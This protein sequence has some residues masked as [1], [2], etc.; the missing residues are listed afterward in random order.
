MAIRQLYNDAERKR[1]MAD[2]LTQQAMTP[3]QMGGAITPQYGVGHGLTQLGQA[4]LAKRAGKKADEALTKANT[5]REQMMAQALQGLGPEASM[6]AGSGG[7]P[8]NPY[9]QMQNAIEAGVDPAVVTA[10]MQNRQP[11]KPDTTDDIKEYQFAVQNGYQGS[12]EE[13]MQIRKSPGTTVNLRNEGQIPT[14]YRA[15]RDEQGNVQRYEPIEGGPAAQEIAEAEEAE[16]AREESTQAQGDLVSQEINRA[17]DLSSGWSTGVGGWVL[18]NV[19][20]T[21]ANAMSNR[22]ATIKANIGFNKLNQMRQESPTGGAL[23]QVSERELG[24]LQSVMGSLEQSQRQ[25]DLEYNLNR[26]WN[27]YQDIIHGPGNGPERR[28]LGVNN[29]QGW[30]IKRK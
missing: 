11:Q 5:E 12:F 7:T 22:L 6:V 8:L 15:V 18:Q 14:G 23:G 4:L 30:S 1:I 16:A 26:L 19:P 25:E 20:G 24:Y 27:T 21:D 9:M 3:M 28:E 13:F 10:Y 2:M 29:L 17:L